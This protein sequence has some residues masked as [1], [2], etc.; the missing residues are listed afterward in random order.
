MTEDFDHPPALDNL[1]QL[2]TD[3]SQA[4]TAGWTP[5]RQCTPV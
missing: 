4:Q 5:E 3:L 2:K 1:I